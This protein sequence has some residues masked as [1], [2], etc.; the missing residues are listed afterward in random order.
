MSVSIISAETIAPQ[1]WRNGGGHT[2]ELLAWPSSDN[3]SLRISR[4]DI[5]KDGPFSAFP[6]VNRWFAVL[7][8][9]G[10]VLTFAEK[11]YTLCMDGEPFNFDGAQSP[12][13]HLIDGPIQDL[14]LMSMGGHSMM[15]RVDPQQKWQGPFQ[16]R[17]LYSAVAGCWYGEDEQRVLKP[18]DFLLAVNESDQ[19]WS[20]VP[21]L[22][23]LNPAAWWLGHSPESGFL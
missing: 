19:A 9:G 22:P 4:A 2:R 8:G 17:G 14:N 13:C 7:Q 10:V 3:W 5:E 21:E 23:K 18:H 15:Q 11:R 1:A 12:A 20:F 6:G 16:I